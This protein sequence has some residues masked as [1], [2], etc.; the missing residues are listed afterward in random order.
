MKGLVL[1]TCGHL[2]RGDSYGLYIMPWGK[3]NNCGSK[4]LETKETKLARQWDEQA[5]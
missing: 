2:R 5:C 1:Y 3:C 4:A